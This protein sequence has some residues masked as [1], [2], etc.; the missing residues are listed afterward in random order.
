MLN[1][2]QYITPSITAD[3]VEELSQLKEDKSYWKIIPRLVNVLNVIR[4]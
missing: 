2:V 3:I 1:G 4:G